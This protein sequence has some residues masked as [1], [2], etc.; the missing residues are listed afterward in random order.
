MTVSE[1]GFLGDNN[2]ASSI[3]IISKILIGDLLTVHI[4]ITSSK[5]VK[6]KN[7]I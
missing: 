2:N 4:C 5:R 6:I 7:F 1:T 3:S